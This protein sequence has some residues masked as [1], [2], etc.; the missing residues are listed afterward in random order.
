MRHR[1]SIPKLGVK[2]AHRKAILSNMAMS[3]I[4]HGQIQTTVSRAKALVPVVSK[5]ITMAKRDDVH[6][7]RLAAT[8]IKKKELLKKLFEEVAPEFKD[9]PGGYTRVIRSGFRKG[10]GA[11]LAVVQLLVEKKV[12]EEESEKKGKGEKKKAK[13]KATSKKVSKKKEAKAQ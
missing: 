7:R 9:R 13:A 8:T 1:R 5:L 3:L 4:D 6:S 11:S 2:T 12:E 10:D